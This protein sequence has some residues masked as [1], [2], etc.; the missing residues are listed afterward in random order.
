MTSIQALARLQRLGVP[1]LATADAAAVLGQSPS[2]TTHT[3][4][5]LASAGLVTRVRHGQWWVAGE[6]NPWVLVATLLSPFDAYIS[7]QSALHLHGV[8]EQIPSVLYVVSQARPQRITTSIATYSVHHVA[9]VLFGGYAAM[10]GA[11]VATVEKALFDLAWLSTGRS[12]QFT[13]LPE[14]ELPAD[15]R[16]A[17]VS[18]WIGRI[19]SR[20]RRSHVERQL[21]KLG[22]QVA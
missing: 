8:I 16:R 9:P 4:S 22:G 21:A 1:V 14:I 19:S 6:P 15:F 10:E 7:L 13:G 12:R 2:A 20:A 18:R 17:E 3:L 5:R 11:P